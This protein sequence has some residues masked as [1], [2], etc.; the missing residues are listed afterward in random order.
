MNKP[1]YIATPTLTNI[2]QGAKREYDDKDGVVTLNYDSD[3]IMLDVTLHDDDHLEAELWIGA[4]KQITFKDDQKN[5]IF[6][7][8]EEH[9]G[10]QRKSWSPEKTQDHKDDLS[11]DN[12]RED[13]F[14]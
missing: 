13:Q 10:K 12:I 9:Y 2:L 4:D 6:L 3:T 8:I 14:S 1:H 7:F 5:N 11:F